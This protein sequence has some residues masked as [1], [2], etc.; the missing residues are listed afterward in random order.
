MTRDECLMAVVV[1]SFATL[2]TAHVTLVFGL[3]RRAP[4]WRA[5]VAALVAPL[6]PFW[7][8]KARMLARAGLWIASAVVYLVARSL[9]GR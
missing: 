2:V 3:A 8:I 7:G 1:L 9:A 4:R 5:A 6:A